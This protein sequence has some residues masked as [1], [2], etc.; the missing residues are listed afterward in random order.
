MLDSLAAAAKSGSDAGATALADLV[1]HARRTGT[2]LGDEIEHSMHKLATSLPAALKETALAG[3]GAA[4]E[5]TAR[6]AEVA[7]GVLSSVAEQLHT[8]DKDD[9]KGGPDDNSRH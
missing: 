9:K 3:L 7:S 5:V 1:K 6:A 8:G 4:R 2:R